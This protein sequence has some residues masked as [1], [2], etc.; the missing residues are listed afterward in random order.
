MHSEFYI[1]VYSPVFLNITPQT[2]SPTGLTLVLCG[3]LSWY[4]VRSGKM[5]TVVEPGSGVG[6]YAVFPFPSPP[7]FIIT[8]LCLGW[9]H[10]H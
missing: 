7:Y 9:T 4:G 2:G 10:R 1:S 8:L 6:T 5:Y 3:T